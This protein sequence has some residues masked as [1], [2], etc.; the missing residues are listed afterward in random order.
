MFYV[1]L[2][3]DNDKIYL[4]IGIEEFRVYKNLGLSIWVYVLVISWEVEI[5]ESLIIIVIIVIVLGEIIVNFKG[6]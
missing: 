6:L 5:L 4:L 1:L 3:M 2:E